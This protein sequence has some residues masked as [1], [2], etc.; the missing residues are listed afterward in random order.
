[1]NPTLQ[2]LHSLHTTHGNFDLARQ[3]SQADLNAILNAATSAA[4]GSNMQTYSIIVLSD[5]DRQKEVAGHVASHALVFCVDYTRLIDCAAQ[6]GHEFSVGGIIGF[7]TGS[8]NTILAAQTA[9]IAA[10]ALGIDSLITNSIHRG[11]ML[12]TYE[13]LGLPADACFPLITVYLGYADKPREHVKG[14]LRGARG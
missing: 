5:K 10:T 14:R 12:R 7:I 1:M 2:T 8:T 4:S 13:Q 11:N 3:V 9:T 6:L